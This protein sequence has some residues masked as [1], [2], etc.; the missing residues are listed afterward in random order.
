MIDRVV[1]IYYETEQE[2]RNLLTHFHT[3]KDLKTILEEQ[4]AGFDCVEI[5]TEA[6]QA[7]ITLKAIIDPY[8]GQS[9]T[10]AFWD[11]VRDEREEAL[12]TAPTVYLKDTTPARVENLFSFRTSNGITGE[13]RTT[14]D[15]F[16][17]H[18]PPGKHQYGSFK[19]IGRVETGFSNE[20]K[21]I[22]DFMNLVY[23]KSYKGMKPKMVSGYGLFLETLPKAE[24]RAIENGKREYEIV[25]VKDNKGNEDQ[26]AVIYTP[27]TLRKKST[28]KPRGGRNAKV[29]NPEKL[30][31]LEAKYSQWRYTRNGIRCEFVSNKDAELEKQY[32]HW[33]GVAA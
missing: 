20:V 30:A 2:G 11:E 19:R 8:H 7:D 24:Q 29:T 12:E 25:W 28:P 15:Y 33:Q 18:V 10:I 13:Y 3:D 23:L 6:E 14:S 22:Q 9:G 27:F 31:E 21:T 32:K 16:A 17:R 4:V 5:V 1:N 26:I